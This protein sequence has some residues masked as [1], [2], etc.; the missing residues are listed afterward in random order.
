[1]ISTAVP[2]ELPEGWS[3]KRVGDVADVTGGG[4][5]RRDVAEYYEGGH[6]AWA[7]PTDIGPER[8]LP[9]RA[10]KT[11]ITEEG[12]RRS[13][14]RLLPRG[15]VLFSSRASIGKIAVAD[16]PIATNQGFA[17]LT[18]FAGIDSWFLAYVLKAFTRQVAAL[19]SGT[20]FVEVAKSS[21]RDFLV[22][23]PPLPEQQRL[24]EKIERLLKQ[25]R[26]AREALDRIT[27]L[28]KRFRQAVLAKAYRGELTERDPSDEPASV[29]LERIREE[30]RRKWEED[31][32]VRGKDP[33]RAKYVEPES[34]ETGGLPELPEG[35]AW[36]S[37]AQTGHVVGGIQK[38]PARTPR[39]NAYPYLRVANVLRGRL[40]LR[41]MLHFELKAGELDRWRLQAGDVLVVEGNGSLSEIGRCAIWNAEIPDCV[42][43]NHIIRIRFDA[44]VVPA[45]FHHYLN[46][47]EGQDGIARVASSTSG[48]YTLSVSKVQRALFP[49]APASE[50]IRAVD[51]VTALFAFSSLIE[52]SVARAHAQ[53]KQVDQAVLARAFR[54]EL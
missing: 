13:S 37:V 45:Y 16:I 44:S 35:W 41:E 47:N 8:I 14:A 32:R 1:M 7:T 53:A 33:R 18:P 19:G 22:P 52:A 25:S 49:L 20:T 26:T 10:T 39:E 21:L 23:V 38:T 46:S 54:G 36:A 12:L 9:L 5:P 24:V 51:R 43:Q 15:T 27:P 48:L 3:W 2:Y 31:L 4:T 17:N 50:Q 29:L 28:L 34:P 30:R 6:I 42:H 11:L 40:D